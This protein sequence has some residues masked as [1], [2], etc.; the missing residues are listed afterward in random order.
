MLV[1]FWKRHYAENHM[2]II[3]SKHVGLVTCAGTLF[4]DQCVIQIEFYK[5]PLHMYHCTVNVMKYTNI[6][7]KNY[8]FYWSEQTLLYFPAWM[9]S[10]RCCFKT[11]YPFC[12]STVTSLDS[13]APHNSGVSVL[14]FHHHCR[15]A[16]IA[17]ITS[18]RASRLARIT[19]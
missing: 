11:Q 3:P 15:A 16:L 7:I 8:F 14:A 2:K 13:T 1:R 9:T 12:E 4:K 5:L 18:T 10:T 19:P 6:Y 17:Q